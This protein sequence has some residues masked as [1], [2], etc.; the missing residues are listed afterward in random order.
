MVTAVTLFFRPEK[1]PEAD[2]AV[3]PTAVRDA[4]AIL[5]GIALI[6]VR[7]VAWGAVHPLTWIMI[8]LPPVIG[9]ALTRRLPQVRESQALVRQAFTFGPA[10]N[11]TLGRGKD[12]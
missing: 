1:A 10:L 11:R 12:V 6:A 9:L 7:G 4:A 5:L 8:L 3:G 2:A